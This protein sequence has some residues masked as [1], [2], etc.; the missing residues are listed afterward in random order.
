M[1]YNVWEI[2]KQK[3]WVHNDTEGEIKKKIYENKGKGLLHRGIPANDS[4]RNR[5]LENY[6]FSTLNKKIISGKH[7]Q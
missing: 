1:S 5:E 6:S 4:R 2:K 7:S 3:I